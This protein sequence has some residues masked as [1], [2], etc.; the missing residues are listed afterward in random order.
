MKP[1]HF[2]I[3]LAFVSLMFWVGGRALHAQQDPKVYQALRWRS[4]GP[5]RGGRVTTVTGLVNDRMVYYMGATGGGVWKTVDAG[6]N[7]TN[8]SDHYFKTGSV[9]S[10]AVSES[11]PNVVYVG[12]GEACLRSDISHGDGVYKST[13]A[14]KTWKNV[15]LDDSSQIG[16]VL[17]DPKDAN[18]V[19][20]AAI[21]HPYGPN[22]ERGVFRSQ[23]GGQTWKN[24]LFVDDKTGSADLVFD[25]HN[26]K[27]I[28]ASMWQVHRLPWDIDEFGP[29][30]GIYKTTDGG[31]TW[32][33]LKD[34][35]P[36]TDMG[37]IGLSVSPVNTDRVW[38]TIGGENGGQD[39]GIFR[40][41]DAG[42]TW[43]LLNNTFEMTSRQYYY[44][45]IFADTQKLDVVYTFSS[46]SFYKSTDGGKTWDGRVQTPHS[47][48][49]DLWIDPHDDQR[50]VNGNDGGA[51]VTFDGGRSWTSENNQPTGQFYTVRADNGFPYRVYGAQQDDTTVSLSNESSAGGRGGL[52]AGGAP[53]DEV[54]G[55]E[56]GY[57]VPDLK[58]PNIVYAGAFWGLL[59]RYDRRTGISR[60]ITVWPDYPGGRTGSEQKY[61][62]QWTFP[63][64]ETPADPGAVYAGGNVVFKSTDQGQ[65]WK[66]ISPDLTRN[67]KTRESL[68]RLEDIY[69]TVFTIAPSPLDKNT[70]WAGSDDGLIH[71]TRDAGKTWSDVTPPAIQ[72]W[73]RI[74]IIDASSHDASTAYAA[75]N[76]YQ[77]DDF[78]P[79]LYRTHDYGRTWTPV[80]SGIPEDTF[81]RTVRQDP[82]QPKLLYAG[83]ETG[84]YV[85]FDDGDHWQSLQLNLPIVPVTDLTLKDGDLIAA[86]QGRAFWILD[87][88]TPLEQ[89]T[90]EVTS[91]PFHLFQPRATYRGGRGG[92]GGGG[93]G[94]GGAG[95]TP[96]GV[97]VD[98]YLAQAA[99]QPVML[100][101]QDAAGKTIKT[102]SSE[103]R[104]GRGQATVTSEAGLN[105][106]GWDMRYPH[107]HGIDGGAF[108]LGG[109]LRGPEAIPGQYRVK[110]TAG[111]QSATQTFEIKKDPRS[112]G[113]AETYRRQLELL[114][115][116]RD[117]LSATSDA[118]NQIHAVE[119]QVD[120]AAK[121]AG[122]NESVTA[123]AQKLD[124]EL[125]AVLHKLYEPRFTGYDDQTL[126][127]PLEMN[128]R[129]A[130]MQNYLGGDAG[131]TDQAVQVLT[132]LSAELD[133]LL[134]KLNQALTI[135]L[136]AFNSQ[137]KA[138]GLS[139]VN[140]PPATKAAGTN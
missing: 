101:F 3:L 21:G 8:V 27:T 105:R 125:N 134:G 57:V 77:M 137:L 50:M 66:A 87:D 5:D 104:G 20:I 1:R 119:Q 75:V 78:H 139:P 36:K 94:R 12:M 84:V 65:S 122:G 55:G 118:I 113:T 24:I 96:G 63:I 58:D 35:L 69:C 52:A 135:D 90:A 130:A 43:K 33:Q 99:S 123:A 136:P 106:F 41:D 28:Y 109:N 82:A 70:I 49:H 91:S 25:P 22:K 39:G 31:D 23:D 102:F 85:S 126:I 40:S 80:T 13:D 103:A 116:A 73:T 30:S 133:Q 120:A 71:I 9:G 72:P 18:L 38:A 34:G 93:G 68:G 11:D 88:V 62:F 108:F 81:V 131:P 117:K 67:D 29:G 98:Y 42:K 10:I 97:I 44:G 7:W 16:K 79:Y 127:Y 132:V 32:T 53:F 14:G 61:R 107:A 89:M 45:H 2:A 115:S 100:E 51:T 19:Y 6:I 86:T 138:A 111:D 4:I 48:Y 128:N 74:N 60:N 76:R 17:I 140:V 95:A 56:S 83:T 54:G 26:S 110:V 112:Q 129:L 64:A 15:G 124:D 46:K 114:L 92:R 121:Q 37:K 59:T 47:D